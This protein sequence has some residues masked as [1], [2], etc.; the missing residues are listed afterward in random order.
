MRELGQGPFGGAERINER[1]QIIG[2]SSSASDRE[3]HT[4]TWENGKMIDLPSLDGVKAINERGQILGVRYV[5][6]GGNGFGSTPVIWEN[7][8]MREPFAG[9]AANAINN[10]GQVVGGTKDARAVVWQNGRITSLGPGVA[11]TSTNV[12]RSS[13]NAKRTWSC[14]GTAPRSTSGR[15]YQSR[16]TT[17]AKSS[18]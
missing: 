18:G 2:T 5:P 12:A 17:P 3:P 11:I 8:K 14:G 15:A 10:R 4:V 1:G 7:G 9:V 13:D 16:S 6:L